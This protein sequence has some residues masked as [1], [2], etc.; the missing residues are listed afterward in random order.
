MLEVIK[1]IGNGTWLKKHVFQYKWV[2]VDS[3]IFLKSILLLSATVKQT[4]SESATVIVQE[5]KNLL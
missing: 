3:I 5:S 2:S 1:L 4:S